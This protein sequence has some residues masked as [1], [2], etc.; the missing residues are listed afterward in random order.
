M[1]LHA[2][3]LSILLAVAGCE[4]S[5]NVTALQDETIG[6]ANHYTKRFDELSRRVALLE[7]RGRSM[8]SIGQPQGLNDVRKLFVDTDKRLK[9]LKT[10][11]SQV[12]AGIASAQK[13]PDPR[14][15]LIKLMGQTK[16]TLHKGDIEVTGNIDAVEQWLAYVEYRPKVASAEPAPQPRPDPENPDQPPGPMNKD[17]GAPTDAPKTDA[18]K[19]APKTDAAKTEPKKDAPKTDAKTEP[20]KDAPKTES[21]KDA[22]KA[23]S[24]S[25]R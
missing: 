24:G 3:F 13:A 18:P 4:K 17:P 16:L 8:V 23:G 22:P 10:V 25:A 19:D 21:K 12:P 1:K 6:L 14:V 9:E 5:S 11:A 15:E 7:Q 2:L 20:N